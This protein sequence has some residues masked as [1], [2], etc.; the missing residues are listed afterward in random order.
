LA[1]NKLNTLKPDIERYLADLTPSGDK[2]LLEMEELA[3]AREFPIVG[4]LVGRFLHQYTV[5]IGAENILE[6]GSGFGY[7][8]FWFAKALGGRGRVVFTE[9]SQENT[10]LARSYFER[11]GVLERVDIKTGN[12]LDILERIDGV[13][14][15][16]F[17]DID[18][19]DYPQVIDRAYA[20]LR[21][22]GIL[23]TDNVLWSGRVINT[24]GTDATRGVIKFTELI[25]SHKGFYTTIVPLRDGVSVSV[26][27]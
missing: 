6:L 12:A 21:T 10:E 27:L 24:D 20:K 5:L 2:I 8:A 14:D 19:E 23:I 9:L 22:G 26:K 15:I 11:G 1:D 3:K 4:P 18:K 13:F 25:Y 16:I 7:S 17:N